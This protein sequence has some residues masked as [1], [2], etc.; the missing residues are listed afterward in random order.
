MVSGQF[1]LFI[2]LVVIAA[3]SLSS[4]AAS[5]NECVYSFFIQTG[6]IF[7][8]GTDSNITVTFG[9]SAG[10][11]IRVRN[12]ENWGVMGKTHDYFERGSLDIFTGRAPCIGSPIC[13]L[14]VTSNGSGPHHGWY[15]EYVHVSST[16]PHTNCSQSV[17]HVDQWLASDA[18][19]YQLSAVL[20]GCSKKAQMKSGPFVV[21]KPITS[22]SE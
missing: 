14:N 3:V 5:P 11:S 10:K 22:A 15:C 2:S 17:F 1:F 18:S 21:R 19:P 13:K 7:G 20:D 6:S 12:I 16:G 4:S 8:A 9:D